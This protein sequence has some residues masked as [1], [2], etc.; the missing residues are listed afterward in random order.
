MKWNV[1]IYALTRKGK[2]MYV[3]QTVNPADRINN[4][5]KKYPR[6]KFI[7]LRKCLNTDAGRIESQVIKACKRMGACEWNTQTW[8]MYYKETVPMPLRIK[9]TG[10][11]F[12]SI[13]HLKREKRI[14]KRSIRRALAGNGWLWF[15]EFT[16]EKI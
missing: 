4:H 3:G 8:P 5:R 13:N 14:S 10:E 6:F 7:I 11:T 9:E 12:I 2:I 1:T 16:I 15:S